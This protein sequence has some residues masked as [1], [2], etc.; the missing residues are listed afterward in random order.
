MSSIS[1]EVEYVNNI[2][3]IPFP[4]CLGHHPHNSNTAGGAISGTPDKC[5]AY[6]AY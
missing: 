3:P 2:A 6:L 1:V 5:A 4:L